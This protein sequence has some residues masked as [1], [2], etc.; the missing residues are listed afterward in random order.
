MLDVQKQQQGINFVNRSQQRTTL[1]VVVEKIGKASAV[2]HGD[3]SKE[4]LKELLMSELS[5]ISKTKS[6]EKED[7]KIS[8]I[9]IQES[10]DEEDFRDNEREILNNISQEIS[11][12]NNVIEDHI[13]AVI[14]LSKNEKEQYEEE[15][16]QK[17]CDT[18]VSKNLEFYGEIDSFERKLTENGNPKNR[19]THKKKIYVKDS[20][21]HDKNFIALRK[22]Q[23]IL[24]E[25]L[26][27]EIGINEEKEDT[28]NMSED[29]KWL[30]KHFKEPLILAMKEIVEKKPSD[31][32]NYLGFWLLNYR[33]FDEN[34]EKEIRLEED[35]LKNQKNH[36]EVD[37]ISVSILEEK[38]ELLIQE[39]ENTEN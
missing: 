8:P 37:K 36:N 11:K 22:S 17:K 34:R 28:L 24:N 32:I 15:E 33:S 13:D 10:I 6:F 38:D 7:I 2:V 1:R 5:L 18:K 23:E 12:D 21:T 29:N 3:L 9:E 16:N 14:D 30:K 35:I 27:H 4:A 19:E 26:I 31:P 20:K 39:E 25:L